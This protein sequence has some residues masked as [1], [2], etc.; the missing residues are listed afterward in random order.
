MEIFGLKSDYALASAVGM[1]RS[2]IRGILDRDAIGSTS[3]L[4]IAQKLNLEVSWIQHGQ[5]SA[6]LPFSSS[7]GA[8]SL[9]S[10]TAKN[11]LQMEKYPLSGVYEAAPGLPSVEF[12]GDFVH[13]QKSLVK[14]S[15]GGG[16]IPI[17]DETFS[18][19]KYAFRLDWLLGI[20]ANPRNVLLLEVDGDSMSPTLQ[21]KNLVLVDR[22]R[23]RLRGG[24]I[25][26][27]GIG[28]AV[29]VKRLDLAAPDRIAILSD[30]PLYKSFELSPD[31]IRII[32]QVIWSAR[33]WV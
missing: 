25:F 24:K 33:T 29:M 32:G 9:E 21:N 26:A 30:N 3:A 5:G 8:W 4:K 19:E 23:A 22:G 12:A 16:F 6:P 13:I 28:E 1:S 17:S 27:I 2:T 14:L 20:G 31:E 11:A 7:S 15:G 18:E 10:D